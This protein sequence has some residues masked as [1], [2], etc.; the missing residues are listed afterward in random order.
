MEATQHVQQ[1]AGAEEVDPHGAL[2]AVAAELGG[3][4]LS[5]AALATELDRRDPLAAMR[6]RFLF[7]L[8][9][10]DDPASGPALYFCG[11]SLGLQPARTRHYVLYELDEWQKR[12][13]EGHFLHSPLTDGGDDVAEGKK[14][15][16]WLTTDENVH[17]R[18]ARVVGALPLEVAIMNGLTV[19]LHLMMVPFYRPTAQRHKILIEGRSFPSDWYAVETQIRFHGYEPSTSLIQLYP[20]EGETTLRTEDIIATIEKEGDSIALVLLSGVQYYTGQFFEIEKI[21]AAGHSK[22]CIVG[23]D[24]AHAVGNVVLKLHEWGVDWACWCSYKYLNSGPGG[25]AGVFVHERHAHRKDLHRFG[26]WWGHTIKT[27]FDMNQPFDP[28]PGAFGF[29]LSNPPVLQCATLFASLEVFEEAGGM[30]KLRAKSVLLTAYLEM[31]LLEKLAADIH[32]FTPREVAQRGCQLSVKF[33]VAVERV[34]EKL[35]QKGVIVD[36]RKPDVIRIAPAPLYNSFS[37]VLRFVTLLA[38]AISECK[39]E[40]S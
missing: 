30:E 5:D 23:W 24:L 15:E 40:S 25:I 3:L 14:V 26:G 29:R 22:G 7:P 38:Q 11:N 28:E 16:P 9:R 39:A 19:N 27:R 34:H 21:T 18:A 20:R 12:G 8:A 31:L 2:K 35:A 4:S 10:P 37:D 13:V 36:V 1:Q 17:A 32:I 33:S 6:D